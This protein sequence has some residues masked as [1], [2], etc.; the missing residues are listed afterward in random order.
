LSV[1]LVHGSFVDSSCWD[2]VAESLRRRGRQVGTVDLH[3]GSLLADIRAV[4]D[5]VDQ[6]GGPVV[7]CGWSYGGMVITGLD[8][9]VGSHLVYLC[10]L[11]PDAGESAIALGER[12][13]GGIDQL[14][15]TDDA[16]DLVLQG[17]TLDQILWA[18]APVEA[19]TSARASL[20]SQAMTSFLESPA[21]IAWRTHPSTFV[22]GRDDRVFDPALV[23]EMAERADHM[24]EWPTSHSPVLSR[25]DLVVDLLDNIALRQ[26]R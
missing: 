8:P 4:Q 16:G 21:T 1:V 2:V 19:A 17:E 26:P 23:R 12:H 11:M 15:A 25:P 24:L 3:R 22:V 14:L 20:R 10:A 18:D 9:P 7:V 6:A 13:P 5:I